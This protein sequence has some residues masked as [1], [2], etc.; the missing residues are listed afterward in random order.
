MKLKSL[1]FLLASLLFT[2]NL[3]AQDGIKPI[4]DMHLHDHSEE[5]Y[6]PMPL[7]YRGVKVSAPETYE[8]FQKEMLA[9]F[10]KYNIVKAMVDAPRGEHDFKAEGIIYPGYSTGE[11]LRL[12]RQL[13]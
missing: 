6:R 12:I 1:L 3:V 11:N 2:S 8:Q 7:D 13:L 5:T 10:K 4:I 9:M